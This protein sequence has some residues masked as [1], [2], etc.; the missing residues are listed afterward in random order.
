MDHY[1]LCV[2]IGLAIGALI[3]YTAYVRARRRL[4][5][6]DLLDV[7]EEARQILSAAKSTAE[8]HALALAT[9]ALTGLLGYMSFL[10]ASL[11]RSPERPAM[12]F[13]VVASAVVVFEQ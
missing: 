2:A 8:D 12:Q 11:M 7:L 4:A 5:R 6:V 9:M 1:L 13:L 3:V 10:G